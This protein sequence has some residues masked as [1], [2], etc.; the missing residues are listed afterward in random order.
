[1]YLTVCVC[2]WIRRPN[3]ILVFYDA[4][5]PRSQALS[6]DFNVDKRTQK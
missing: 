5:A 1:M 2:A 6:C 4:C 3:S